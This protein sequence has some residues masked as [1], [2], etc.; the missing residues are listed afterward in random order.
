MCLYE[1]SLFISSAVANCEKWLLHSSCLSVHL[2]ICPS[3]RLHGTTWLSLNGFEWHLI[4][5]HFSD[6][7]CEN[8]VFIKIWLEARTLC[9][10]HCVHL[11]HL[12]QLFL[13]REMFHTKVVEK[14]K[15]RILCSI[16][17]FSP[18]KSCR[19]W[20]YEGKYGTAR[21]PQI[22]TWYGARTLNAGSLRLQTH[23]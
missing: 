7:C 23:T 13:E 16:T 4:F 9:M 5:E 18:K 11:S 8:S 1:V 14:I 21:K 3:V 6:I 2:S 20:D 19:L 10:K 12:V 15:T 22:S 17:F